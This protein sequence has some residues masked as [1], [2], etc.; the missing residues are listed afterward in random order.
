MEE[1]RSHRDP[2]RDGA[3]APAA[4]VRDGPIESRGEGERKLFEALVRDH[5]DL[6]YVFIT[7]CV[8]RSSLADEVHQD[9]LLTAWRRL[10]DFDQSRSFGAWLRGIARVH[11]RAHMRIR[12]TRPEISDEVLDGLEARFFALSQQV[13]DQ[14]DDKLACLRACIG[15]LV[16]R[17]RHAIEIRYSDGLR[18][19]PLAARL[20]TSVENAKK[21]VQRARARLLACMN[22]KLRWDTA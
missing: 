11:I 15:G 13:G 17:D 22:R 12:G 18:G 7:S 21:I 14:L 9:T 1:P 8:G 5:S 3:G 20:Q 10:Q 6:L 16:E 2:V 4:S 19:S